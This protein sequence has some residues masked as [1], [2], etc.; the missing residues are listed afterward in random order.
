MTQ[1]EALDAVVESITGGAPRESWFEGATLTMMVQNEAGGTKF[2]KLRFVG[3]K[4]KPSTN[5][6]RGEPE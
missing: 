6:L 3:I 2:V 5:D 4:D 1:D